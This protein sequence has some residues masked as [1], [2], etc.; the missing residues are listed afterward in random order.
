MACPVAY[1]PTARPLR[2]AY[3]P[4]ALS[5]VANV[6]TMRLLS[7]VEVRVDPQSSA[8]ASRRGG[9]TRRAG[10]G[11]APGRCEEMASNSPCALVAGGSASRD[12]R[13]R[14]SP[15]RTVDGSSAR[16]SS[17]RLVSGGIG[18]FPFASLPLEGL[19]RRDPHPGRCTPRSKSAVMPISSFWRIDSHRG[20]P[21]PQALTFGRDSVRS[22][23]PVR[24]CA[25]P[26]AGGRRPPP[27][28]LLTHKRRSRRRGL[29][30]QRGLWHGVK[31]DPQWAVVPIPTEP[32]RRHATWNV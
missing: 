31:S 22:R 26:R 13:D 2:T 14:L 6:P 23:R 5:P 9:R 28:C 3:L 19:K 7:G 16:T 8:G 4:A 12:S 17:I 24:R 27:T 18:G 20:Q 1:V 15:T 11:S 25:P 32:A 29:R 10:A 21:R 30:A